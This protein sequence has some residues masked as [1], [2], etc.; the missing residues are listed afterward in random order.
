MMGYFLNG[1]EMD[2][3]KKVAKVYFYREITKS[4][5]GTK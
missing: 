4:D 1:W 3:L 2:F 5:R